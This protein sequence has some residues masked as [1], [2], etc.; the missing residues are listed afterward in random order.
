MLNSLL[1]NWRAFKFPAIITLIFIAIPGCS[2]APKP[3]AEISA[4]ETA[5][6][7]VESEEASK[8]APVRMDRAR[9]K[10]K[11]ARAA[12]AKENYSEAKRLAEEAQADAELA[13]AITAKAETDMAVSELENSIKVLREEIMRARKRQ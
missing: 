9:Q 13:Q 5:L 1:S 7:A 3:V 4:A 2:S 8:H 12:M 10:L 11:Q 6:I